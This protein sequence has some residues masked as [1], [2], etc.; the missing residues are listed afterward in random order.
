M[1]ADIY[2]I[3]GLC[4][5]GCVRALVGLEQESLGAH[6]VRGN[7]VTRRLR[8]YP[9]PFPLDLIASGDYCV[10]LLGCVAETAPIVYAIV[11]YRRAVFGD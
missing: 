6:N 2:A 5:C 1:K 10:V 3:C 8:V 7:L 4:A 9:W 11:V